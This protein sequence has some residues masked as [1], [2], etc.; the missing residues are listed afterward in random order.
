MTQDQIDEITE[1]PSMMPLV[2]IVV[3][4]VIIGIGSTYFLGKNN[5][6]EVIAED[7]ITKETGFNI[8]LNIN[9]KAQA[10]IQ[11]IGD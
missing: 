3:L 2:I 10:Y 6:I 7:V 1:I 5:P 4:A 8:D 11:R 9:P